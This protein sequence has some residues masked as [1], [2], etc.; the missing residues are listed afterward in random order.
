MN[1]GTSHLGATD[2][3]VGHLPVTLKQNKNRSSARGLKSDL[4]VPVVGQ[5]ERDAARLGADRPIINKLFNTADN[6]PSSS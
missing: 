4:R 3:L 5:P 1:F 2:W 6:A